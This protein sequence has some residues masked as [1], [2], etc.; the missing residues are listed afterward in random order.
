RVWPWNIWRLLHQAKRHLVSL[1]MGTLLNIWHLFA[2]RGMRL[3]TRRVAQAD[4]RAHL[5]TV[6]QTRLTA[7]RIDE[8]AVT[9]TDESLDYL[10]A[11]FGSN[12]RLV[13]FFLYEVF[14]QLA[15]RGERPPAGIT[16]RMLH[17]VKARWEPPVAH[18]VKPQSVR[19]K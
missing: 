9:L 8:T 3:R 19:R 17:A 18:R 7:F 10:W 16:P 4:G 11:T 5:A 1:L 6:I 14:Q 15:E 2:L 13:D 12:L